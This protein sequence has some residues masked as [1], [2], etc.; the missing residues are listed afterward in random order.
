MPGTWDTCQGKLLTGSKSS[1][2]ER[3]VL[4]SKRAEKNWRSEENFDIRHGDSEFSVCPFG[5]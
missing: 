4:E 5:F 2:R 1:Q 3:I